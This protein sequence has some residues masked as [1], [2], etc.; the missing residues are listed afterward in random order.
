MRARLARSNAYKVGN[1]FDEHDRQ[2][3]YE[4]ASG[5]GA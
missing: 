4:T 3:M 2:R 5:P 1:C